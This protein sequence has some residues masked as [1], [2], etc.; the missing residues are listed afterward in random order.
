MEITDAVENVPAEEQLDA[1]RA[2][3]AAVL[4]EQALVDAL[5]CVLVLALHLAVEG[6]D[7]QAI[8]LFL[9]DNLRVFGDELQIGAVVI[10]LEM[11]ELPCQSADLDVCGVII[12]VILSLAG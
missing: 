2:E 9:G 1:V 10:A 4:Q 8:C 6:L 7:E 12:V 3:G 5:A 11:R